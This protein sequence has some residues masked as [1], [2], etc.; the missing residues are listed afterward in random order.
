MRSPGRER[1]GGRLRANEVA[2]V[3]ALLLL[4][5]IGPVVGDIGSCGQAPEELDPRK[6]FAL[7]AQIDCAQ[8]QDCGLRTRACAAACRFEAAPELPTGCYPLVHDGEVCLHKLQTASCDA[9]REHMA[10]EGASIPTECNFCPLEE[11]P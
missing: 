11:A 5:G 6:F 10:D 4:A 2:G 8:C 1:R 3:A 7:K 9:Y